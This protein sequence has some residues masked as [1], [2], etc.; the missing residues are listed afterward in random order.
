M[1]GRAFSTIYK[2]LDD[3]V[4]QLEEEKSDIKRLKTGLSD[5]L[6]AYSDCENSVSDQIKSEGNPFEFG[7]S[8]V[9]KFFGDLGPIGNMI[10]VI[11]N[12]ISGK[13][14]ES[15]DI[16]KTISEAGKN[17][18]SMIGGISSAVSKG[19]IKANWR[20]A[21]FGIKD[22]DEVINGTKIGSQLKEYFDTTNKV[23]V[24]TKWGTFLLSGVINGVDN[25]DEYGEKVSYEM[26]TETL[27]ETVVDT[28]V[29]IGAKCA[30]GAGVA[31]LAAAGAG[32][33]IAAVA[34]AAALLATPVGAA[35]AVAAGTVLVTWFANGFCKWVTGATG[36]KQRDIGEVFADMAVGIEKAI[37]NAVSSAGKTVAKWWDSL[38]SKPTYAG[39]GGSW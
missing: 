1:S 37:G 2:R 19:D 17:L 28:F 25:Y 35:V 12:L 5:V 30:V 26:L 29:R 27:V 23:K 34:G 36:E 9:F 38:I 6:N 10:A 33:S 21:L 24:S 31:W 11:G 8:Q 3:V 15:T 4:E 14:S 16:I 18:L 22:Y 13:W 7:W 39:G 20:E 32:S